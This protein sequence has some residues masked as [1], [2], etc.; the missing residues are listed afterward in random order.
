MVQE[1]LYIHVLRNILFFICISNIYWQWHKNSQVIEFCTVMPNICKSSAWNLLYTTILEP[2]I[3]RLFVDFW[4]IF[5]PLSHGTVHECT[6]QNQTAISHNMSVHNRSVGSVSK[7]KT[8][9]EKQLESK[10]FV[11]WDIPLY[12]E[13]SSLY[14]H[15]LLN[16][17]DTF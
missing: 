12:M 16:N 3:L 10:K 17:G 9:N 13:V 6:S 2:R 14:I 11:T 15:V 5:V 4:K 7:L 8:Q 1:I